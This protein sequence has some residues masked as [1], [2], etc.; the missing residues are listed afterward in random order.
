MFYLPDPKVRLPNI[1]LDP[2]HRDVERAVTIIEDAIGEFP[3]SD[4]A[5][6]ANLYAGLLTPIIRQ[7]I[8]GYVPLLLIDAPQAGNGKSLLAEIIAI[9]MTGRDSSLLVASDKDAEMEK[10]ITTA[11]VLL[12]LA[13]CTCR[14][15]TA[16]D[17]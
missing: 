2:K 11:L 4:D 3:F 17:Y 6:R 1:S 7:Y 16:R 5:S 14:V 9:I 15:I 8:T 13:G 12:L 10:R